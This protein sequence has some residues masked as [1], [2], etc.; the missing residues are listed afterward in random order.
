MGKKNN[1]S[2]PEVLEGFDTKIPEDMK[3]MEYPQKIS[4][5]MKS[6]SEKKQEKSR[7]PNGGEF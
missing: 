1:T 3:P 2:S 7:L 6:W 4:L 5:D